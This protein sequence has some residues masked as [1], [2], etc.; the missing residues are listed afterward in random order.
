MAHDCLLLVCRRPVG[1][2]VGLFSGPRSTWILLLCLSTL[3]GCGEEEQVTPADSV[4]TLPE[5]W[6]PDG[7]T[8]AYARV[9]RSTDV[10]LATRGEEP[11]LFEENASGS[12]FS[13]DGRW[14]AYASPSS[15]SQNVFVRP[16]SGNGKN[17]PELSPS[18]MR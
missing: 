17:S 7:R 5:S 14:I 13:P 15:G 9:G 2:A 6:S 4:P 10:F 12:V 18:S 3:V 11:R 16:V 1:L 8:L